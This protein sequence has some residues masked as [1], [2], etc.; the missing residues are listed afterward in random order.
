M[1]FS[2]RLLGDSSDREFKDLND[3]AAAPGRYPR[4]ALAAQLVLG[5]GSPADEI[6]LPVRWGFSLTLDSSGFIELTLRLPSPL[7]DYPKTGGKY[8]DFL[9]R[10]D[11]AHPQWQV[12]VLSF[13]WFKDDSSLQGMLGAWLTKSGGTTQ[14]LRMLKPFPLLQ[15][16]VCTREPDSAVH[17]ATASLAL[18]PYQSDTGRKS[19]ALVAVPF[20]IVDPPS[21]KSFES[22][23]LARLD[24]IKIRPDPKSEYRELPAVLVAPLAATVTGSED[25]DSPWVTIVQWRV[26]GKYAG[27]IADPSKINARRFFE[28]IWN[29]AV[30]YALVGAR[31]ASAAV[32]WWPLPTFE[33]DPKNDVD[34]R[35]LLV[36]ATPGPTAAFT[37]LVNTL[38]R[39]LKQGSNNPLQNVPVHFQ[40][41]AT[42]TVSRLRPN[43]SD[44]DDQ[45]AP[46]VGSA[47]NPASVDLNC[48]CEV[49]DIT[50]W[51]DGPPVLA[52][53][54]IDIA[55][56]AQL[57]KI[58]ALRPDRTDPDHVASWRMTQGAYSK[59]GKWL[60]L[61]SV[62]IQI[63]P[64]PGGALLECTLRGTWNQS[65]CDLYPEIQLTKLPCLMRLSNTADPA[66]EG[67]RA[68]FDVINRVEDEM[69]R[70][71][72]PFVGTTASAAEKGIP[73]YLSIRVKADP[74][75]NAV[76][77]LRLQRDLAQATQNATKIFVQARPFNFA[78]LSPPAFDPEAGDDFAIWRND[79]PEGA[80]WRLPEAKIEFDLPPQTVAE[81]MERGNR[82][83]PDGKNSYIDPSR[84]LQ[85]RFSPPAHLAVRPANVERRY[86]KNA[87]NL[88]AV[89]EGARVEAFRTELLYPIQLDFQADGNGDPA[90][91]IA[92]AGTFLGRPAPNLPVRLDGRADPLAASKDLIR[93]VLPEDLAQWMVNKVN[94]DSK[95]LQPFAQQYDQLR[96]AQS[97][98]RAQFVA[99][100]AQ[101]HLFDPAHPQGQIALSQ[102]MSA[103]LRQPPNFDATT[104]ALPGSMP[105]LLSPL[106][107]GSDLTLEQKKD[108]E[109]RKFLKQG[110]WGDPKADGSLR[111]GAV[112][113]VEFASELGAILSKPHAVSAFIDSI[114]FS[115]LG[116]T[117]ASSVSFDEGRTTFSVE[118][119]DGQVWRIRKIRIGRI[120]IF[121]NRAKHVVV[122]ERTVIPSMQFEGQQT[123]VHSLTWPLLRKTE[124]Y[125]EPLEPLRIFDKEPDATQNNTAFASA[126]E[127]VTP[128]VYVDGVWGRDCL[129]EERSHGYEIPLWNPAD[130]SGFYPKPLIAVVA[131]AGAAET[132][133]AWHENPQ[134]I[135]FYTNT[136]TGAGADSDTW[137]AK[138]G[139]DAP[140]SGPTRLPILMER[141]LAS[142]AVLDA[143]TIPNPRLTGARRQ[144]FDLTVRSDGPVNIQHGRGDTEMLAAGVDVLSFSR[145]SAT[146]PAEDNKDVTAVG[147]LM[148]VSSQIAAL[149]DQIQDLLQSLP[150]TWV[151]FQF[152]CARLGEYLKRQVKILFDGLNDRASRIFADKIPQ[153]SGLD[154]ALLKQRLRQEVL[155]KVLPPTD[156]FRELS[157]SINTTLAQIV[158]LG[159]AEIQNRRLQLQ[160]TMN[161]IWQSTDLLMSAAEQK[162]KDALIVPIDN[163]RSD[164][165]GL[166]A[167]LAS[168]SGALTE[169][170]NA[171]AGAIKAAA[172]K[173]EAAAT[174]MEQ[175]T[176]KIHAPQFDFV[177][178]RVAALASM[179]HQIA[180]A[181]LQFQGKD[182]E[183]FRNKI[184]DTLDAL[185]SAVAALGGELKTAIDAIQAATLDQA[186]TAIHAARKNLAALITT[187]TNWAAAA[188]VNTV[189]NLADYLTSKSGEVESKLDR[190][191][192]EWREHILAGLGSGLDALAADLATIAAP[193][194]SVLAAARKA[195]YDIA[196][197]VSV[198]LSTWLDN[199]NNDID[200]L[201]KKQCAQLQDFQKRLVSGLQILAD[202]ISKDVTQAATALID[203]A[204]SDRMM[205]LASKADAVG[206]GLKLMKAIGS[207]P[208]LPHLTFNANRVEYLFDD[209]KKEIT[210]SPFAARLAEIDT[211]LKELG[212]AIPVRKFLDQM[213]PDNFGVDFN[214]IFRDF[215]G[216]DF[217]KL[218]S[219]FRLPEI[220]SDQIQITH[221]VD[222]PTRSAWAKATVAADYPEVK[223]LFAF[224]PLALR[225]SGLSLRAQSDMRVGLDGSRTN[226]TSGNLRGTWI[227]EF[228]GAQLVQFRDVTVTLEGGHFHVNVAPNN[229]EL[230]PALK[231]VSDIAKKIGEQVPPCIEV[232]RDQRGVIVGARANLSTV[233]ET[234]PPSPPV[235]IGPLTLIG[236]LGLTLQNGVGFVI[237][238]HVG[239][240]QDRAHFCADRLSRRWAL[241]GIRSQQRRWSGALL[242]ECR[243]RPWHVTSLQCCGCRARLFLTPSVCICEYR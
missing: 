154:P 27:Q 93:N 22:V 153:L 68:A 237:G 200:S 97:A 224:G 160:A 41:T 231:F 210:T 172:D 119:S 70:A 229:I 15:L 144:R 38:F 243:A 125:V 17:F 42:E 204:T 126:L 62:D 77:E 92:E 99:R 197:A 166:A 157:R 164:L 110:A 61:G 133:R 202:H 111:A 71:T 120:A 213:I 135:Y 217:R 60:S 227:L 201:V 96:W 141:N 113:T 196:K 161:A 108:L 79:D 158:A 39:G 7:P 48:K 142:D 50:G 183:D 235:L 238:P 208:A 223:E 80:Q 138:P 24:D 101:F 2:F 234:P 228:Q 90:I 186:S 19:L 242:G 178:S 241:A 107:L 121:W 34:S 112:H 116:A 188:V 18:V 182:L 194:V 21:D 26:H 1:L 74:T 193:A 220:R 189:H 170:K 226:E 75:R 14:A 155:G 181:G 139:V 221:G 12:R 53:S 207:L 109:T 45:G 165:G 211:G 215:G 127:F 162:V 81:E 171:A 222:Q 88:S 16:G 57:S 131:H 175:L 4:E 59:P 29:R 28:R 239:R 105:P 82:F 6:S 128:R 37:R 52:E 163:A 43:P 206:K 67:L 218:F 55:T 20:D 233:I 100:I 168:L 58:A 36:F 114:A 91:D 46:E 152:D 150:A 65:R 174:Q 173:V 123:D 35:P 32:P 205:A 95:E 73:G 240:V 87:N 94:A 179:G 40:W 147:T 136:E 195:A 5:G 11:R 66:P 115:T 8:F 184:K 192:L 216:I 134:E 83:W 230:H 203:T 187:D 145:T 72:R 86:N 63:G 122:Y 103:S 9:L 176:T 78:Q 54:P 232:V 209:L 132:S 225:M 185:S 191:Y 190:T 146:S 212:L 159:D 76:I 151:K 56:A 137:P 199:V 51:S 236:G 214:K 44:P 102:G 198:Q 177:I 149:D 118:I 156:A 143:A 31:S 169:L 130:T 124:E 117:G 33:I 167:T 180:R 140:D 89:L 47:K 219:T 30:R 23:A 49:F 3:V 25:L 13:P 129:I 69:Q 84:P 64:G 106:A 98:N 85:Y 148:T 104:P 10:F